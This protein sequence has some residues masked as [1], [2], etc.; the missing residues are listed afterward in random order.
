M[1]I[2]L[3]QMYQGRQQDEYQPIAARANEVIASPQMPQNE[4]LAIDIVD[5][6]DARSEA[7]K[8]FI[9][10]HNPTLLEEEPNF[11]EE[12]VTIADEEGLDF[13]LLP[14]IAMNESGLCRVIPENSHNCLGLGVHSRGT[15]GFPSY[16]ENFATAAKILK[17]NYI[18][19]GLVTPEL[20]M[21]KYTPSSPNGAW[22]KAVNQFM[23]EIRYNDRVLG[24]ETENENFVLEFAQPATS[25]ISP[26][27]QL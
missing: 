6:Q 13:R 7:I 20:I 19:K 15:W 18:D 14:A 11:H 22:A 27:D 24:I 10:R 3:Y 25:E 2:S 8:Q 1:S 23:N 4:Q 16:G 17:K 21:T 5:V 9:L 26:V 12:L